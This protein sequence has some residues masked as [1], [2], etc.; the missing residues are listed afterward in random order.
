MKLRNRI[1]IFFLITFLSS[2]FTVFG[3]L[4]V[5]LYN[6]T[7]E[8]FIKN[9]ESA[10][11]VSQMYIK[12]AVDDIVNYAQDEK[13]RES[14]KLHT[15][16]SRFLALKKVLGNGKLPFERLNQDL[17]KAGVSLWVLDSSGRLLRILGRHPF[18]YYVLDDGESILKLKDADGRY[19]I[20]EII[21][22]LSLGEKDTF[23]VRFPLVT[24]GDVGIFL[25]V[26]RRDGENFI[27]SSEDFTGIYGSI[28]GY[29]DRVLS[30]LS[31]LSELRFGKIGFVCVLDS[32][33]RVVAFPD[34]YQG[35]VLL[36]RDAK[37]GKPLG[38]LIKDAAL[39]KRWMEADLSLPGYGRKKVLLFAIPV[40]VKIKNSF[41]SNML[42]K[43]FYVCSFLF[44][45]EIKRSIGI[46]LSKIGTA[47]FAIMLAAFLAL[48]YL[49]ER[50]VVSPINALSEFSERVIRT[51]EIPN[52]RGN[53]LGSKDEIGKLA[54]NLYSMARDLVRSESELKEKLKLE[55]A[56]SD[57]LSSLST[58]KDEAGAI[59]E[60]MFFIEEVYGRE[61]KAAYIG[62]DKEAD[63]FY[64]LFS[65][66]A[67]SISMEKAK[68]ILDNPDICHAIRNREIFAGNCSMSLFKEG[69]RYQL[70][71][72][73]VSEGKVVG[74]LL[75][76]R[77][78]SF[79]GHEVDIGR[80][81][82]F[83]FSMVIERLRLL[84]KLREMAV[85]DPLTGIHNRMFLMEFLCKKLAMCKRRGEKLTIVMFDL[86][87]FKQINDR[88]G[89]SVGD[90][91][92]KKF[93]EILRKHTRDEDIAARYGGEEFVLGLYGVDE[94][95]GLLVA[96]RIREILE[97]TDFSRIAKGL[98]VTCSAGI[99]TYPD[100]GEDL[101][102][103]LAKADLAMYKA[104]M[105]GRN[106]VVI[107]NPNSNFNLAS[108]GA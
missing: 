74:I 12:G 71:I 80:R 33:M 32:F 73:S 103:L 36:E 2:F 81:M 42:P 24:A 35:K 45:D 61:I 22:S 63:I 65:I 48:N 64:P 84:E 39:E 14:T 87:R 77:D 15:F 91:V 26:G 79:K 9:A 86:D 55:N 34:L 104:K 4:Y 38:D 57:F 30:E 7:R 17:L 23:F 102:E 41:V 69:D 85:K 43:G 13:L 44:K 49:L 76:S 68:R 82:C 53:I 56:F 10:V 72:P 95:T 66:P 108:S 6:K 70:C 27:L 54:H 59:R 106:R 31:H 92:L 5:F 75:L 3:T 93:A 46:A 28:K 96:E 88:Y 37:S 107:Y 40:Y 94:A 51:R 1:L 83:H 50:F 105:K 90:A 19:F 16:I 98:K 47:V 20:Q 29:R 60:F 101:E 78:W 62:L 67:H 52:I 97:N 89:H 99:A 100:H 21:T 8:N 58:T 11:R 18:F 25:V